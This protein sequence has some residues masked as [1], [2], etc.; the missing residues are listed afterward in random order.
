MSDTSFQDAIDLM[1][2]P[3][4]NED[5]QQQDTSDELI[6]SDETV[7]ETEEIPAIDA[8]NSWSKAEKE[9]F[10]SL[11]PEVQES[12]V[13]RER[14]RDLNIRSA[15]DET[16]AQRKSLEA[17]QSA[18]SKL[19]ADYLVKL[20]AGSS[21]PS[22][23]LLDDNNESYDPDAYHSQMRA[24]EK[25][26]EEVTKLEGELDLEDA[27]KLREWQTNEIK[28][29]QKILP[30]FVDSEKG[31]AFR[32]ELAEYVAKEQGTTAEE[33]GRQFPTTP[34]PIMLMAS[35]AMKY[36][37][38]IARQKAGKSTPQSKSLSGGNSNAKPAVK[39]N[40]ADAIKA[41]KANPTSETAAALFK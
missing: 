5:P 13:Q 40:R 8:P 37:A 29:Y 17:D 18:V 27:E 23:D 25:Q 38:A 11:P 12:L 22:V 20:K 3:A 28:V 33:V 6:L 14:T 21:K 19:K 16:A 4:Q 30:E 7:I 24:H 31:A 36:D 26:S 35:K 15:Q 10:S 39:T 41:Y 1:A 2:A 34:A 9:S 32:Q